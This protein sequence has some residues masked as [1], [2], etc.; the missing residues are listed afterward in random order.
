MVSEKLADKPGLDPRRGLDISD[1]RDKAAARI[2]KRANLIAESRNPIKAGRGGARDGRTRNRV[3]KTR[4]KSGLP[5]LRA[6]SLPR[7]EIPIKS[8]VSSFPQLSS[9]NSIT[10]ML[11]R[12][13]SFRFSKNGKSPVAKS[14]EPAFTQRERQRREREREGDMFVS[15][16]VIRS[17]VN[18][19]LD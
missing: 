8:I 18:Q 7:N 19:F 14:C 1:R 4:S 3:L 12:V 17:L 6:S 16:S 10:T 5:G 13:T 2:N 9:T 15:H 11:S